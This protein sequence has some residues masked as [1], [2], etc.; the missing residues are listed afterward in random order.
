[1]KRLEDFISRTTTTRLT[2]FRNKQPAVRIQ[3]RGCTPPPPV[4]TLLSTPQE[5]PTRIL[6]TST[7]GT[8]GSPHTQRAR[9]GSTPELKSGT[10]NNSIEKTRSSGSESNEK[11]HFSGTGLTDLPASLPDPRRVP[12]Y[13]VTRNRR[14]RKKIRD[15][16]REGEGTS[17][18]ACFIRMS[19]R[20]LYLNPA[21]QPS[22][23]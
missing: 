9:F 20:G 1:M 14:T 16:D 22:A 15:D 7:K 19:C 13:L 6:V 18:H 10:R 2:N 17:R 3:S 21:Y 23:H 12:H 8:I 11:T 4:Q 5:A